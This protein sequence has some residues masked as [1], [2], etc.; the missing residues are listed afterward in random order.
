MQLQAKRVFFFTRGGGGG[1]GVPYICIVQIKK[2]RLLS[3]SLDPS[4]WNC[5][6]MFTTPST[7]NVQPVSVLVTLGSNSKLVVPAKTRLLEANF[8]LLYL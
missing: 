4:A 5:C 3:C 1:G 6:R 2:T 7:N 8:K